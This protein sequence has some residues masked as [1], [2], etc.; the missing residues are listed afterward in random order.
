MP[1]PTILGATAIQAALEKYKASHCCGDV[2]Y[3][4]ST[5]VGDRIVVGQLVAHV[6]L[7]NDTIV[8]TEYWTQNL[9]SQNYLVWLFSDKKEDAF[10]G[11]LKIARVE[12]GELYANVFR[13]HKNV[14]FASCMIN[15]F[16][17]PKDLEP[18]QDYVISML[19]VNSGAL[20]EEA[21]LSGFEQHV[22]KND[23]TGMK[24]LRATWDASTMS[25][26]GY[27]TA[28]LRQIIRAITETEKHFDTIHKKIQRKI[29]SGQDVH[30]VFLMPDAYMKYVVAQWLSS[31]DFYNDRDER[32]IHFFNIAKQVVPEL[33]EFILHA[34]VNPYA[35]ALPILQQL[36]TGNA[37]NI[38]EKPV[39][40]R[41]ALSRRDVPSKLRFA[42]FGDA[43]S[44]I[45][46]F[47]VTPSFS[48]LVARN[49][50]L[51]S[52]IDEPSFDAKVAGMIRKNRQERVLPDDIFRDLFNMEEDIIQ[53]LRADPFVWNQIK[54]NLREFSLRATQETSFD[55]LRIVFKNDPTAFAKTTKDAKLEG[56]KVTISLANYNATDRNKLFTY[57]F[58]Q[59]P[60]TI[61]VTYIDAL[62]SETDLGH[63]KD[64]PGRALQDVL[65]ALKD[66]YRTLDGGCLIIFAPLDRLNRLRESMTETLTMI[67]EAWPGDTL[68]QPE[69]DFLWSQSELVWQTSST[70]P[71]GGIAAFLVHFKDKSNVVDRNLEQLAE[72]LS[73][74]TENVY[75]YKCE[76][77]NWE[78]AKMKQLERKLNI[79]TEMPVPADIIGGQLVFNEVQLSI[80]DER[81]QDT[82]V[83]YK[84]SRSAGRDEIIDS[85]NWVKASINTAT[86][87]WSRSIFYAEAGSMTEVCERLKRDDG[88]ANL[89]SA[90]WTKLSEAP[91]KVFIAIPSRD[92]AAEVEL[93]YFRPA[94][95]FNETQRLPS[96]PSFFTVDSDHNTKK[97]CASRFV[98][99]LND[100][101]HPRKNPEGARAPAYDT[102]D[103]MPQVFSLDE[104]RHNKLTRA[105]R[106]ARYLAH[107]DNLNR[108]A[109]HI[110]HMV[111][112]T[113]GYSNTAKEIESLCNLEQAYG[114]FLFHHYVWMF[115]VLDAPSLAAAT[116]KFEQRRRALLVVAEA[117]TPDSFHALKK[118]LPALT[119]SG[120]DLWV[121]PTMRQ[122][123]EFCKMVPK[124]KTSAYCFQPFHLTSSEKTHSVEVMCPAGF[125]EVHM[126]VNM[127]LEGFRIA[128]QLIQ[129]VVDSDEV[130]LESNFEL[131]PETQCM[132]PLFKSEDDEWKDVDEQDTRGVYVYRGELIPFRVKSSE[133][134][135]RLWKPLESSR[136]WQSTFDTMMRAT[137]R[138]VNSSWRPVFSG[139][140]ALLMEREDGGSSMMMLNKII[141]Y[142]TFVHH[143]LGGYFLNTANRANMLNSAQAAAFQQL[144][145]HQKR[146]S[147]RYF[148]Y[149][150]YMFAYD[151]ETDN[152]SI[153]KVIKTATTYRVS[154][155][156]MCRSPMSLFI[157]RWRP[158]G[159]TLRE[160]DRLGQILDLNGKTDI[161]QFHLSIL[162]AILMLQHL[163]EKQE[164]DIVSDYITR[165]KTSDDIINFSCGMLQTLHLDP[166]NQHNI[167][168][169]VTVAS[170]EGAGATAHH[171]RTK[172]IRNHMI[173]DRMRISTVAHDVRGEGIGDDKRCFVIIQIDDVCRPSDF[174]LIKEQLETRWS[175]KG[176]DNIKVTSFKCGSPIEKCSMTVQ[177]HVPFHS[178]LSVDVM[179]TDQSGRETYATF[180]FFPAHVVRT[181]GPLAGMHFFRGSGRMHHMRVMGAKNEG[182]I[183]MHDPLIPANIGTI[184]DPH[185]IQF[186]EQGVISSERPSMNLS[187]IVKDSSEIKSLEVSLTETLQKIKQS[188]K[189]V[190]RA[191]DAVDSDALRTIPIEQLLLMFGIAKAEKDVDIATLDSEISEKLLLMT[192]SA[193][194][195]VYSMW[196]PDSLTQ[197]EA[198]YETIKIKLEHA[199]QRQTYKAW[200]TY[201]G[202]SVDPLGTAEHEMNMK[203]E[204]FLKMAQV[205]TSPGLS[206]GLYYM[207]TIPGIDKEDVAQLD[208]DTVHTHWVTISGGSIQINE[209]IEANTNKAIIFFGGV[210][211]KELFPPGVQ[212]LS[213]GV[214]GLDKFIDH[215]DRFVAAQTSFATRMRT[216]MDSISGNVA[217]L[218]EAPTA[219]NTV[220]QTIFDKWTSDETLYNELV[221]PQRNYFETCILTA[222]LKFEMMRHREVISTKY[223]DDLFKTYFQ[224]IMSEKTVKLQR[225]L[226]SAITDDAIE[227]TQ[228]SEAIEQLRLLRERFENVSIGLHRAIESGIQELD[229]SNPLA[230]KV[231][232][233][234]GYVPA[235]GDGSFKFQFKGDDDDA[236]IR[237]LQDAESEV[238]RLED[239]LHKADE[240]DK[241]R[242]EAALHSAQHKK[243]LLRYEGVFDYVQ[244]RLAKLSELKDGDIVR[245]I[246]GELVR[247]LAMTI[248]THPEATELA[249]YANE[250]D[251]QQVQSLRQMLDEA[252]GSTMSA[253]ELAPSRFQYILGRRLVQKTY[254]R[255]IRS[256]DE[257][258]DRY[259]SWI[260]YRVFNTLVDDVRDRISRLERDVI[261]RNIYHRFYVYCRKNHDQP[262]IEDLELRN[263]DIFKRLVRIPYHMAHKLVQFTNPGLEHF[264]P[265]TIFVARGP[266]TDDLLTSDYVEMD[267]ET[268][269]FERAVGGQDVDLEAIGIAHVLV[270]SYNQRRSTT[271]LPL[272][273]LFDPGTDFDA[274]SLDYTFYVPAIFMNNADKKA[275]AVAN[276]IRQRPRDMKSISEVLDNFA[277]MRAE[278]SLSSRNLEMFIE[279]PEDIVINLNQTLRACIHAYPSPDAR[280]RVLLH[281]TLAMQRDDIKVLDYH[282]NEGFA[283]R[284]RAATAMLQAFNAAHPVYLL[285]RKCDTNSP[286]A[287]YFHNFSHAY[288]FINSTSTP[289]TFIIESI[290]AD[291]N[292]SNG[293]VS[294]KVT[295]N[296]RKFEKF[297]V[298]HGQ[299]LTSLESLSEKRVASMH[300]IRKPNNLLKDK[301]VCTLSVLPWSS[302]GARASFIKNTFPHIARPFFQRG[303][304]EIHGEYAVLHAT[305]RV[306]SNLNFS[307]Y[308][309]SSA[310]GSDVEA[311]LQR[312]L[313]LFT[314]GCI[315]Q[316]LNLLTS[317]DSE[318][319]VT[320]Q[321]AAD[322]ED[323]L[324]SQVRRSLEEADGDAAGSN[325]REIRDFLAFLRGKKGQKVV[326]RTISDSNGDITV[327]TNVLEGYLDTNEAEYPGLFAFV[328]DFKRR[329]MMNTEFHEFFRSQT[330]KTSALKE[331]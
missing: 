226:E 82:F 142:E 281:K 109:D 2:T 21:I 224:K 133:D 155:Q 1:V 199:Y 119:P 114:H 313:Y 194:Q 324:E 245:K 49:T 152:A 153:H 8:E 61:S 316:N 36:F 248:K 62:G 58:R 304:F 279:S 322:V 170:T 35:D 78:Q 79:Y 264:G 29:A 231:R 74:T 174:Q 116:V 63:G 71:L 188:G 154:V 289:D 229:E 127:R 22:E 90:V 38:T 235:T 288:V 305:R 237:R 295:W 132:I 321:S 192:P 99:A 222:C 253:D 95:D 18:F 7:S 177:A 162:L 298:I 124:Y 86:Q 236:S 125:N 72:A 91:D 41:R 212:I 13:S 230:E 203:K 107:W 122:F 271:M 250:G 227:E 47:G 189:M 183:V 327:F 143:Q 15:P 217:H 225:L 26:N 234:F 130:L 207:E 57:V 156:N 110:R 325:D 210:F 268:R 44:L 256:L 205:N 206:P 164:Q 283:W 263:R 83:L 274:L 330:L 317:D 113:T 195:N 269:T 296:G 160:W 42:G 37:V 16:Q 233:I 46:L 12:D 179:S 146:L 100:F 201:F 5:T 191:V 106:G 176:V 276:W 120:N 87:T 187:N 3:R 241:P 118:L 197:E 115:A 294:M 267:L 180:T 32:A 172:G 65:A 67:F 43:A 291:N 140:G 278:L 4:S 166:Y 290:A 68:E 202:R 277:G 54:A 312:D 286:F 150:D 126:C 329:L 221:I 323:P 218:S 123:H 185:Y 242:I 94:V 262:E 10:D 220:P 297:E 252:R 135:Q 69:L 141:D 310:N 228:I 213:N 261:L 31:T 303:V 173:N 102:G 193:I 265:D 272:N 251:D 282:A 163:P 169:S 196:N 97:E 287:L 111:P 215:I 88:T 117:L 139:A 77:F 39:Q 147:T 11:E 182:N 80:K 270:L 92:A 306:L 247:H 19:E 299:T 148:D 200:L 178:E 50:T 81:E 76:Y 171:I 181:N 53:H 266:I 89:R 307:I 165:F 198:F 60:D 151:P 190:H 293:S 331:L 258:D 28:K 25:Y 249:M 149:R 121:C 64:D 23:L 309:T 45:E 211:V 238:S 232:E 219:P 214:I 209:T 208:S 280:E 112:R 6:Y 136:V 255:L 17:I 75:A 320:E 137:R 34:K 33:Q 168:V 96:L 239:A 144:Q 66:L 129:R 27:L 161:A 131:D 128:E 275:E 184:D 48:N 93:Y 302:P 311:Q 246:R 284:R 98:D 240:A 157:T 314:L 105:S 292:G 24:K 318:D 175:S 134:L 223:G 158:G 55:S 167:G 85:N 52:A 326:A 73:Y 257:D 145:D 159:G 138:T 104:E 260:M 319:T 40:M 30:V 59:L 20:S 204:G 70:K 14:E 244:T 186:H 259:K 108:F 300:F 84:L 243:T 51:D 254:D 9:G 273:D 328:G 301:Y 315:E 56:N 285:S 103:I 216:E 308:S 101:R